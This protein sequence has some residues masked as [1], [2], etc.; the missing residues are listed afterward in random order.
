MNYP[1]ILNQSSDGG[2]EEK[3]DDEPVTLSLDH[4]IPHTNG[5]HYRYSTGNF[6]NEAVVTETGIHNST[7]TGRNQPK[8]D[9]FQAQI[10]NVVRTIVESCESVVT[11]FVR[12]GEG[13]C[14]WPG[15]GGGGTGG[16]RSAHHPHYR[17]TAAGAV[18][19]PPLSITDELRKLA[20]S[21]GR[22][23]G[24]GM[25]R[26]DIPRFLGEEAVYSFDDD[27]ISA[28]S[29]HT[30]EEMT[31]HG[32]RQPVRRKLSSESSQSTLSQQQQH[33]PVPLKVE[34]RQVHEE[35][36]GIV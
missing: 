21:E 27:N 7:T 19:N 25:R 10:Q 29:Q 15:S 4:H 18:V 34:L 3:K 17:P 33:P 26:A 28:I 11:F 14:P 35:R 12:G 22:V 5:L 20:E 9:G 6:P 30:L 1:P 24:G 31:K 16:I 23:F 8:T 13:G 2:V 32:I 36:D